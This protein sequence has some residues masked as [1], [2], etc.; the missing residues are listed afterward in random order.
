MAKNSVEGPTNR[1]A[2]YCFS[3]VTGTVNSG[4][5]AVARTSSRRASSATSRSSDQ[6]QDLVGGP[7]AGLG[8]GGLE[9][10]PQQRFGV[11]R[12]HV[13]PEVAAVDRQAVE[14]VLGGIGVG[15]GHLLHGRLL[16]G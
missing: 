3:T 15:P 8:V 16:V 6:G 9:V 14:R 13:E 7:A 12:P 5:P 1:G 4:E 10:E 2:R 11:R